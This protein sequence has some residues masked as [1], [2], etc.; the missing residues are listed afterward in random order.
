MGLFLLSFFLLHSGLLLIHLHL[1]SFYSD[2]TTTWLIWR[3]LPSLYLDGFLPPLG[4][5]GGFLLYVTIS[6]QL[7]EFLPPLGWFGGF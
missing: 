4:W 1:L 2:F 7:N 6:L 3:I 5:F